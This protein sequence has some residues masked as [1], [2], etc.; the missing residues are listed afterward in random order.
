[1]QTD[2]QAI[3][4]MVTGTT[5]PAKVQETILTRCDQLPKLYAELSRTYETRFSDRIVATVEGMIR[6]LNAQE[7]GPDAPQLAATMVERMRAMHTRYGISVVLKPPPVAKPK[8]K[9]KSH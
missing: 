7:S 5:L 9:A 3:R 8:R 2:L 6:I 4:D 1:V